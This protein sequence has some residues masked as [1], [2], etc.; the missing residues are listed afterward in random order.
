MISKKRERMKRKRG[1]N[2]EKKN[3]KNVFVRGVKR[4]EEKKE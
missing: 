2:I 4:G 3:G 1:G